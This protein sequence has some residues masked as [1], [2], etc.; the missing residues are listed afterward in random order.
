[1]PHESAEGGKVK[2]AKKWAFKPGDRVRCLEREWGNETVGKVYTVGTVDNK[3]WTSL[4][5]FIERDDTGSSN[6]YD[7]KKFELVTDDSILPPTAPGMQAAETGSLRDNK[8]KMP[9]SEVP[10]EA[11]EAIATVLYKSSKEGGG[12]YPRRN[13]KKGNK[14]SVPMDSLL[15]HAAKRAGG[16]MKDAESGLP[17]SW[18]MLINAVFLV[19]YE[20]HFPALNDL[21]DEESK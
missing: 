17:H 4:D 7:S 12:K 1:M 19:F 3:P 21:I 15:R 11:M 10:L 5:L 20:K 2:R 16:E 6:A 14:H 8:G 18:H 13:W 9:F